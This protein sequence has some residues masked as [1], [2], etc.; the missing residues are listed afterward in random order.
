MGSPVSKTDQHD[1]ADL[2][3][4]IK[5]QT[6]QNN[7]HERSENSDGYRQQDRHWPRRMASSSLNLQKSRGRKV[8]LW[9]KPWGLIEL[10]AISCNLLIGVNDPLRKWMCIAA[11]ETVTSLLG[12][13]E[14]D[15]PST[16]T[17]LLS[18]AENRYHPDQVQRSSGESRLEL[19]SRPSEMF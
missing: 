15:R 11:V 2:R 18:S 17:R 19:P 14:N 4:E 5:C 1:H 12:R 9:L 6:R 13:M 16:G 10:I 7:C 3:I 8:S